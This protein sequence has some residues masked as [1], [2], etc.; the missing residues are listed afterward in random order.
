MINCLSKIL[1]CD[2]RDDPFN[3]HRITELNRM[4]K[5]NGY[6]KGE[7]NGYKYDGEMGFDCIFGMKIFWFY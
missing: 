4:D 5:P 7:A 2:Y 1:N 6:R 3:W